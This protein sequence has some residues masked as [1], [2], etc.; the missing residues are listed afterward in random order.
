MGQPRPGGIRPSGGTVELPSVAR[1]ALRQPNLTIGAIEPA[2][3]RPP[4]RSAILDLLRPNRRPDPRSDDPLAMCGIAGFVNRGGEGADP[5]ILAR[6]TATIAHRGPDGDGHLCLGPAALGHRRLSIID[7]G[8]GAQPMSQRGR[9]SSGITL[10]RRGLQRARPPG[11]PDAGQRPHLTGP[12]ERHREPGP[13]LRGR[14]GPSSPARLNG[15]FALAIWDQPP[16][17]PGPGPRPD[18]PEAALLRRDPAPGRWSSAPRAK[19]LLAH[20]DV[21]RANS[22][23]AGLGRYLFYEYVPG[24][25]FDLGRDPQAPART[26]PGPRRWARRRS[27]RFWDL[28]LAPSPD[29]PPLRGGGDPVLGRLPRRGRPAPGGRTSPW[30]CSCRAGSTRRAWPPRWRRSSRPPVDPDVLD[31]LRRPELRR[32]GPRPASRRDR[33]LGT[34]H[35]ERTFSAESVMELLPEVSGWLD[36]P[37]GDASVLPTHLLSRFAREEV[38]VVL[39]G[40]GADELL[41]G[42]PDVQGRAGL[43]PV[44]SEAAGGGPEPW[45]GR[46]WPGCR[47]IMATSAS[48]SSSSSSSGGPSDPTALAHQRWL[49]SFSGPEIARLLVDPAEHRRRRPSHVARAGRLGARGSTRLTRSLRLYQDTYLP[50]RHPDQGRPGE[51]GLRP[52]S[53]G[54]ISRCRAR[55]FDRRLAGLVQ[56]WQGADEAPAQAGGGSGKLPDSGILKRPKKGFGIPVARWLRGPLGPLMDS[57]LAPRSDCRGWG[58]SGPRRSPS[59]SPSTATR[60]RDHRRPLWTL[61]MFQLWSDRWLN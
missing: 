1:P 44:L 33:A 19:A 2:P 6:M 35:R 60:V 53:P 8:N 52:R 42:Y 9:G 13:P 3:S 24:P 23:R 40:D 14:K 38:T 37:F 26:C 47:S 39:G 59:A 31:R 49:G 56:V 5:D 50:G 11:P 30:A 46:R 48:T 21:P 32:V 16:A 45:R 15:M 4:R 36:E 7:V 57:L 54:P 58:C 10:Q 28:P 27:A 29:S 41:A 34:D 18:G 61:L 55:G 12:T 22:I 51:H 43:P 20:P 17:S 25:A